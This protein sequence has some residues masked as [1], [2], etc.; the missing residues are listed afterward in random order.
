MS[1]IISVRVNED[2]AKLFQRAA[3]LYGCGVSSLL[4]KFAIERLEDE[5]DLAAVK[6]YE[7]DKQAGTLETE[8]AED[9]F[10][11]VSL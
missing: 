11:R 10:S 2:E 6:E 4:K 8:P 9:Y 3:S 7:R 1:S 5:F